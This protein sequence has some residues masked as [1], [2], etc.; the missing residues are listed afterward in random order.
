M[1]IDIWMTHIGDIEMA[2]EDYPTAYAVKDAG[3]RVEKAMECFDRAL[4]EIHA[5]RHGLA[6]TLIE[7]FSTNV[8]ADVNLLWDHYSFWTVAFLGYEA[9][10]QLKPFRETLN[11]LVKE[12]K[13]V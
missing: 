7:H 2:P 11:K 1:G 13:P 10:E 3:E 8:R 9:R 6:P 5:N 12:H 4:E